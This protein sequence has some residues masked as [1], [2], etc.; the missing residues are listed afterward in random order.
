MKTQK[1]RRYVDRSARHTSSLTLI[2]MRRQMLGI[3]P[4]PINV[5]H[6]IPAVIPSDV[7]QLLSTGRAF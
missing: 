1:L 2:Q 4:F 6:A 7:F 3:S 5:Q